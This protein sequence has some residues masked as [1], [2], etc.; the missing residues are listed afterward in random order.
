MFTFQKYIASP[1]FLLTL[2]VG[3]LGSL[4]IFQMKTGFEI[5]AQQLKIQTQ[6]HVD[7]LYSTY[8]ANMQSCEAGAREA[9]K[10]EAFVK[11][12]CIKPIND[13]PIAK[14]LKE[15]GYGHLLVN[16]SLE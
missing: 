16:E 7:A 9:E 10:D 6:A 11:E 15:W 2:V 5:E 13:S 14:W 3:V 4:L 1:I 8:Q 12:N